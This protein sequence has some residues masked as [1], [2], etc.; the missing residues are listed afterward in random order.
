MEIAQDLLWETGLYIEQYLKAK[1][2]SSYS[3]H[4]YPLTVKVVQISGTIGVN[5]ALK[6]RER[7][8]VLL[9][10]WFLYTGY[11]TDPANHQLAGALLART[12]Y[13]EKGLDPDSI[14]EIEASILSTR[15]PQ[16]PTTLQAQVL[17]DAEKAWFADRNYFRLLKQLRKEQERVAGKDFPDEEWLKENIQV[18][19]NQVY[20]TL[21]ARK[22]FEK[23]I[24]K[25][26]E[27]LKSRLDRLTKFQKGPDGNSEIP[28]EEEPA[29][30]GGTESLFRITAR[31]Q[32]DLIKLADGKAGLVISIN[33]L[34]ISVVLSILVTHLDSN[35]YLE[36]P[37]LLL[38]LTN[39]STIIIALFATR[40]VADT[41]DIVRR[42]PENN[43]KN[44]LSFRDFYEMP[45]T[46]YKQ[47]IRQTIM[48]KS[49]LYDSLSRDIYYQGRILDRKF[50]SITLSYYIF[51][52]GLSISIAGFIVS[53]ILH[54]P[55]V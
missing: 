36:L 25:N 13:E 7:S 54:H 51:I 24:G 9:S 15:Y 31:K 37:T 42:D 29:P 49:K 23:K 17:C 12:Y 22:T 26:I 14:R 55:K 21:F 44:I 8:K 4:D 48:D 5:A 41:D 16:Q 28:H 2:P 18:L 27:S 20:F 47:K 6:E 38:V 45:L 46:E 30:P 50:R 34:I 1:L 39:V 53:F 32:M 40:P 52:G 33:A 3:F 10:A 43:E 11:C 19:E 35:K